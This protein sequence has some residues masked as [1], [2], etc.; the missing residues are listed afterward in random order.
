MVIMGRVSVS[1]LKS[2]LSQYLREVGRGG[3][4]EILDRGVPIAR[5]SALPAG[6]SLSDGEHRERLIRAGIV[7]PGA[8]DASKILN[9]PP[10]ELPTSILESLEEERADRL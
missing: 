5:L 4:V 6:S 3:E 9:L 7:R 8:G 1:E 2:H 10:L